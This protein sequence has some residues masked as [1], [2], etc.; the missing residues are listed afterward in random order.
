VTGQRSSTREDP[1]P[2]YLSRRELYEVVWS[3][4]LRS[5]VAKLEISDVGLAKAC[6]RA[7]VP[8]PERGHWQKRRAGKRT[9]Q[10]PLPPRP[11]GVSD[12]V[13]LGA[14]RRSWSQGWT[15]EEFLGPIPDP[16]TFSESESEVRARAAALIRSVPVPDPDTHSHSVVAAVLREDDRRREKQ[17]TSTY[18][19]SWE[20][21]LYDSPTQ[22]R[23]L[24][25]V[26]ALFLAL[27]PCGGK[28][29]RLG[30]GSE[31]FSIEIGATRVGFALDPAE[32]R[33]QPDKKGSANRSENL[34]LEIKTFPGISLSRTKWRD[35]AQSRLENQLA[36]IAI[37]LLVCAELHYRHQVQS[38]YEW[39]IERQK[40]LEERARREKAER[41][42]QE[43]ERQAGL[44]RQRVERLLREADALRQA[45]AIRRYVEEVRA[46]VSRYRAGVSARELEAWAGWALGQADAIDPVRS[47]AFLGY[48][49][50]SKSDPQGQ[51]CT[52]ESS[53]T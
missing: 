27:T 23:R 38:Q 18:A 7:H 46:E 5:L 9:S 3:E 45:R 21:P 16:P 15:E 44:Q 30:R 31:N 53:Q 10:T 12:D 26:N 29:D 24:R 1:S 14:G 20:A 49:Q 40:H 48:A 33:R 11:L 8:V 19:Y 42:R 43:R 28:P 39:R 47:R 36:E 50:E 37:E 51:P 4:P 6:R 2:R 34:T 17:R 32:R 25:I 52:T 13:F 35:E 41:E 22:R